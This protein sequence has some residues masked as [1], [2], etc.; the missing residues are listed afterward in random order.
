MVAAGGIPARPAVL[1]LRTDAH[2]RAQR[3]LE[4]TAWA[5]RSF[6]SA[7][8]PGTRRPARLEENAGALEITLTA[9]ELDRLEPL[10]QQ[11]VGARY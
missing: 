6:R 7:A 11:V 1:G 9:D 4:E 8:I 3:R 10:S 5:S 2:R